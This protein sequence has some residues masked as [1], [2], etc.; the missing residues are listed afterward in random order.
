MGRGLSENR[1]AI[2]AS[3][4]RALSRLVK[5]RL[6]IYVAQGRPSHDPR[7]CIRS[8]ALVYQF[9]V[10]ADM[11]LLAVRAEQIHHDTSN[12]EGA[13]RPGQATTLCPTEL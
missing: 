2:W 4:S 10:F 3:A 13:I 12:V 1:K 6:L 7:S 8:N 9:S 11:V 5:R